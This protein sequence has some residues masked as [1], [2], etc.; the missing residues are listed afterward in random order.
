[1]KTKMKKPDA[2]LKNLRRVG[3][4]FIAHSSI[5]FTIL[6]LIV[7][8]Y[9]IVNLNLILNMADDEA[10]R[11]QKQSTSPTRFDTETIERINRLNTGQTSTSRSLPAGRYN[12][13]TE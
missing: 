3:H 12:P 10:Y 8:G 11:V 5:I 13:F 1:M 4:A 7:V 9:A 6:I 2:L